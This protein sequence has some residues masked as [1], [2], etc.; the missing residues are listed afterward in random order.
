MN[1]VP[2]ADLLAAANQQLEPQRM[3]FVFAE[4]QLPDQAS[5]IEKRRF[6]EGQ[7]GVLTPVMCVDKLP[8]EIGSFADLV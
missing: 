6:D 4:S 7:G 1:N 5:E 8:S 3:L 2:F